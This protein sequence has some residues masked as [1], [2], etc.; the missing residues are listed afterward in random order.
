MDLA[1]FSSAG[2]EF[3]LRWIHY[4]SG[5]AWI[6]I[7]YYFNFVQV[8]FF[9]ETEPP[10]RTG[11]IIKLVPRALWWFRWAAMATFVTGVLILMAYAG[12]PAR[13][14]AWFGTASGAAISIGALIGTIMFLN[15][16]LVIWPNQKIVIAS[17]SAVAG[18]G[19]ADP[20]AA[21]AG[22]RAFVASRTNALLSFPMLFFMGATSHLPISAE[23]GKSIGM[24]MGIITL[25]VLVFEL[26]A[27]FGRKGKGLCA[28]LEKHVTVIHV[29]LLLALVSYLIFDGLL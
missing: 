1:L 5:V 4:F 29:G 9:A 27:L 7:L 19:Q 26:N 23:A 6:G 2:Y 10:V 22:A 15:V 24:P 25:I 3:L 11:A 14:G 20:R 8:P 16:W 12:S 21:D 17:T 13:G 18:G 28:L